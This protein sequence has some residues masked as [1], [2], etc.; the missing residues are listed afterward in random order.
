[1]AGD[2]AAALWEAW[3]QDR[4]CLQGCIECGTLQHPPAQVCSTCHATTIDLFDIDGSCTLVTWSTVHRAPAPVFAPDVPYTVAIVAVSGGA[5]VQ[6]RVA[7]NSRT[8]DFEP[9]R[10]M[11]LEL[12][13]V[14]GRILPIATPV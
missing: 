4:L 12:G 6:A 10:A 11:R 1:M 3:S 9:G 14:A 7:A 8:D 5:L 2:P 13:P